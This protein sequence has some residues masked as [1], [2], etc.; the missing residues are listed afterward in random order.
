[1]MR[2]EFFMRVAVIGG[3]DFVG[4]RLV[5]VLVNEGFHVRVVNNLDPQVHPRGVPRPNLNRHV[6]FI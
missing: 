3:A 5:D 1:M 4:S 2:R 6:E